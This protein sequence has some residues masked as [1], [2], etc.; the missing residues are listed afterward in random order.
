MKKILGIIVIGLLLSGCLPK[1]TP[2]G[3]TFSGLKIEPDKSR[4]IIL[5][6]GG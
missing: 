6:K 4:I 1:V 2:M 3:G 5:R